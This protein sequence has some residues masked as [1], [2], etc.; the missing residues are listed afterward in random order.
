MKRTKIITLSIFLVLFNHIHSM[1][2]I[3]RYHPL[4][5]I[6]KTRTYKAPKIQPIKPKKVFSPKKIDKKFYTTQQNQSEKSSFWQEAKKWLGEKLYG[7]QTKINT[8]NFENF[9][10]NSKYHKLFNQHQQLLNKIDFKDQETRIKAEKLHRDLFEKMTEKIRDGDNMVLVVAMPSYK[11]IIDMLDAKAK[12]LDF[13]K[14]TTKL[15]EVYNTF[16]QW[17]ELFDWKE[18]LFTIKKTG[19]I[20]SVI[21]DVFG[22]PPKSEKELFEEQRYGP[23]ET[24]YGHR[25]YTIMEY[26]R[27]KDQ[28]KNKGLEPITF[29]S[30]ER[31]DDLE[32][33]SDIIKKYCDSYKEPVLLKIKNIKQETGIKNKFEKFMRS[34]TL[35][36]DERSPL[37]TARKN[38]THEYAQEIRASNR[39]EYKNVEALSNNV[40]VEFFNIHHIDYDKMFNEIDKEIEELV[41]R[42]RKEG[43]ES[44]EEFIKKTSQRQSYQKESQQ[45]AEQQYQ[46]YQ[47]KYQQLQQQ[48]QTM[49]IAEALQELELPEN[50]TNMDV[51]KKSFLRLSKKHHP[52]KF[53]DEDEKSKANVKL[54]KLI[55]AYEVLKLKFKKNK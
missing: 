4:Q 31:D 21:E 49:T 32:K 26:I 37:N 51:I 44:F 42:Y 3:K 30:S 33:V 9:A 8:R 47:K 45:E 34:T 7:K 16:F 5:T 1:N 2:V 27:K 38:F 14:N 55:E 12:N 35:I 23:F 24:R 36:D 15:Y 22:S 13:E 11:I 20:T 25:L 40:E 19:R 41:N 52:D 48:M 10:Q 53:Q 46:E 6:K 54:K 18:A 39:L 28:E 29:L 50:E 17:N 43:Q